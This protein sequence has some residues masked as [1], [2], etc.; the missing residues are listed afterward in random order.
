MTIYE[1]L[2]ECGK[3]TKSEKPLDLDEMFRLANEIKRL[4]EDDVK[5]DLKERIRLWAAQ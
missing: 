3:V 2:Q 5:R 1:Q 4:R